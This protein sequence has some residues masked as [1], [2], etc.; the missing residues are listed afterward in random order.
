MKIVP[1][2]GHNI[3]GEKRLEFERHALDFMLEELEL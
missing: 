3:R 1:R 2:A